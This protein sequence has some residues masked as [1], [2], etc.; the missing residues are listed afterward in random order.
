MRKPLPIPDSTPKRRRGGKRYRNMRM[1]QQMTQLM[2]YR[3]RLKFG[4]DQS[5]TYRYT[6]EDFGM[7]GQAGKVRIAVSK[8]RLKISKKQ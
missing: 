8:S 6:G 2:K 3:N 7:L 1:K 4:T 5:S